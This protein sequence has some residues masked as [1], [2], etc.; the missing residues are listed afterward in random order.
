MM[1]T[2]NTVL[3]VRHKNGKTHSAHF[4]LHETP[5]IGKPI[6]LKKKK[7]KVV[8]AT[9]ER[10]GKMGSNCLMAMRFYFGAMR[11]FCH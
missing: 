3:K 5:R 11:T 7:K 4:Y 9:Q 2:D 8:F 1:N 6:D 10:Q